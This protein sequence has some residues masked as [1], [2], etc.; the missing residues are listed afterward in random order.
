MAA[1]SIREK[2][3]VAVTAFAV[4]LL[5]AAA[6]RADPKAFGPPTPEQLAA[7]WNARE[8]KMPEKLR[9]A[10]HYLVSNEKRPELFKA[11]IENLGGAYVGV[12]SDQHLLFVGWQ[13][14]EFAWAID[15]DDDVVHLNRIHHIFIG[16][17]PTVAEFLKLWEPESKKEAEALL[18]QTLSPKDW[19]TM[20]QIYREGV[21]AL[22]GRW[23]VLRRKMEELKYTCYLNDPAQYDFIRALIKEKRLRAMN[24]NLFGDVGLVGIG[25]AARALKVPVRVFYM[26][27]A[28]QYLI[29]N[30]V[31]RRNAT[32]LPYDDKSL[33]I[34]TYPIVPIADNRYYYNTQPGANFV[35][36][37]ETKGAV[38]HVSALL[39]QREPYRERE[40]LL[41]ELT[42]IT[43][44]PETKVH[45]KI[46]KKKEEPETGPTGQTETK[47]EDPKAKETP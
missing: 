43:R 37:M 29:Y 35:K 25:E 22:Q 33:V 38:G 34:R 7:F 19:K 31:F 41:E 11:A 4:L 1:C 16:A 23:K 36:W 45:R 39:R 20:R 24:G 44:L 27:N 5:A 21:H 28:E 17:S 26:S 2:R 8:D 9:H 12:G 10:Q 32:A 6:A 47:P 3:P 13:R 18:S 46:E 42:T 40:K 14:P 30:Q 15:Y